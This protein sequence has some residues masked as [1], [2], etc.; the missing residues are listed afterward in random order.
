MHCDNLYKALTIRERI[1]AFKEA[2]YELRTD[3]IFLDKWTNIKG[4][5]S[6]KD[7]EYLC[8]QHGIT[9]DEFTYALKDFDIFEKKILQEEAKKAQWHILYEKVMEEF[10]DDSV[11]LEELVGNIAYTVRPFVKYFILQASEII[12]NSEIQVTQ[13]ALSKI[14]G[15]ISGALGNV[16]AKVVTLDLHKE[17]ERMP[18]ITFEKYLQ[19]YDSYEKLCGFYNDHPTMTRL[20][21]N[22]MD[23]AVDNFREMIYALKENEAEVMEISGGTSGVVDDISFGEGDTHSRGKTVT[24]VTYID[25]NK[26]VY[27]PKQLR[28][29]KQFNALLD[30]INNDKDTGLLQ[31]SYSKSIYGD[32]YTLCEFINNEECISNA[33]VEEYYTRLGQLLFLIYLLNGTDFHYENIIA[34]RGQVYLIDIETLFQVANID[35][36]LGNDTAEYAISKEYADS[37]L[38]VGILPLLGFNQNLEGKSVDI[39]ALNGQ[40]QRLPF[41]VLQM[42]N[43]NTTD[44]IFEYDFAEI[45]GGGNIPILDG[46]K[47]FFMEHL[48]CLI[49]GF[50]SMSQYIIK[51]KD[52]IKEYVL[53][54][55]G[56]PDL[57]VRQLTKATATYATLLQYFNHPN[58]LNDMIYMERLFENLMSYPYADKRIVSY[59]IADM[60]NGDIPIFFSRLGDR[61]LLSSDMSVIEDYLSVT[62]I[63]RVIQKIDEIDAE[64]IDMQTEMFLS[65]IG[66]NKLRIQERINNINMNAGDTPQEDY[67][68]FDDDIKRFNDIILGQR[69]FNQK[70]DDFTWV[71]YN[72]VNIQHEPIDTSYLSG[73]AG[74]AEYFEQMYAAYGDKEYLSVKDKIIEKLDKYPLKYY[75]NNLDQIANMLVFVNAEKVYE[76]YRNYIKGLGEKILNKEVVLNDIQTNIYADV[77]YSYCT[78]KNDSELEE[79]FEKLLLDGYINIK[80]MSV[81]EVLYCFNKIMWNYLTE[82]EQK[83]YIDMIAEYGDG[84][85]AV[86]DLECWKNS[87]KDCYSDG[88]L[89][90]VNALVDIYRILGDEK[91]ISYAKKL[92]SNSLNTFKREGEFRIYSNMNNVNVSLGE[93]LTGI[94]YTLLRTFNDNRMPNI[95]K[96][97]IV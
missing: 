60:L 69:V 89:Y 27:K 17:K 63:E 9:I 41:K 51:N 14:A 4:L 55:F 49:N 47:Q 40:K 74:V 39:S 64:K 5:S 36:I 24:I 82:E 30:Y 38:S 44:M 10:R 94:S 87:E 34:K 85:I 25:G 21:V 61:N 42:K 8:K 33:E 79:L 2:G 11:Q 73:L 68:S 72:G 86:N 3:G 28:I 90:T 37:V 12:N 58:Y 32:T 16:V 50:D 29:E 62:P 67:T 70:K 75:D 57:M 88:M 65:S 35:V 97:T 48:E 56:Q 66:V 95:F 53:E 84:I 54:V 23:M 93:G 78:K 13:M 22:K 43:V 46:E 15:W 26:I 7:T 76:K 45:N 59:E 18:D 71:K 31:M 91:Y 83:N 92:M 20:L 77:L 1:N 52:K 19:G 6:I 81:E 80:D 96:N